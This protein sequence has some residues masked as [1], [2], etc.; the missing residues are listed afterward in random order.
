MV[1]E[2]SGIEKVIEQINSTNAKKIAV[3]LVIAFACYHE[4]LH[5]KY[6]KC[7]LLGFNE[8]SET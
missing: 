1:N 3:I 8:V 6:G 4:F 5:I 7:K 2:K